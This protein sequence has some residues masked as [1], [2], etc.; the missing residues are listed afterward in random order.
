MACCQ[1]SVVSRKT[2][3]YSGRRH[4]AP[5]ICFNIL[6]NQLL[7]P[8][9]AS[10]LPHASAHPPKQTH[11]PAAAVSAAKKD[12]TVPR[13]Q[14]HY[15]LQPSAG[16][17]PGPTQLAKETFIHKQ[18]NAVATFGMDSSS[19]RMSQK[20]SQH[21]E[22]QPEV[23]GAVEEQHAD[24]A[25]DQED[26]CRSVSPRRGKFTCVGLAESPPR[27][28]RW[29]VRLVCSFVDYCQQFP[30]SSAVLTFHFKDDYVHLLT[31]LSSLATKT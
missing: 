5:V 25:W 18:M 26:V 15:R 7:Q 16:E 3:K 29:K 22:A 8:G 13:T 28:N 17:G 12:Q 27:S 20:W 14:V 9:R 21:L 11:K 19:R 24:G 31:F 23:S 6:E 10:R 30:V 1:L 4:T 2:C